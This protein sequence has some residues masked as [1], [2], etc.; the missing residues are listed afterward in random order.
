MKAS[1]WAQIPAL[2]LV[3]S[4]AQSPP[5]EK[6]A[7]P[8][9][10]ESPKPKS[11]KKSGFTISF[12]RAGAGWV[13]TEI[14]KDVE[15]VGPVTVALFHRPGDEIGWDRMRKTF[16]HRVHRQ[17]LSDP[18]V[19]DFETGCVLVSVQEV[20]FTVQRI[21]CKIRRTGMGDYL[22]CKFF[23]DTGPFT[24]RQIRYRDRNGKVTRVYVPEPRDL[25]LRCHRH[26]R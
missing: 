4:C 15:G 2:I 17:G 26:K 18:M 22:G 14:T 9:R 12:I 13:H 21:V 24:S 16:Q 25:D 5:T 8:L 20:A 10:T 1:R 19:V 23:R 6:S 11:F 7:P 3:V